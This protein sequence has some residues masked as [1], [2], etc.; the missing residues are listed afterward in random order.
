MP[1]QRALRLLRSVVDPRPWLHVFRL[2]HFFNYSHVAQVRRL[3]LGPGAHVAPNVSL[4]NAERV[5]IGARSHVNDHSSLWAGNTRGR[6][7]IGEDCLIAPNVFVTAANYGVE[8]GSTILEQPRREADVTVGRDVWLGTGV[9]VLP[10]VT[11]GDGCVVGA[12]AVVTRSLPA[13]A[14]AVGVPAK[15]VG[16]RG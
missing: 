1:I 8:A 2:V 4:R 13:G 7:V 14:V 16:E 15:V 11:I 9:I 10:G 5:S 12:G 6:I 3:S